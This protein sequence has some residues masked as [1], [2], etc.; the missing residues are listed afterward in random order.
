MGSHCPFG[1][2]KHKLWSK[3]TLRV[4]LTIWL[5]TTKSQ[6]STRF[7]C[8]QTTCNIPLE[9]ALHVGYNVF[10]NLIEIRGLH[11]KLWAPKVIGI[12]VMGILGLPLGSPGTKNHLDVALVESCIVYYKGDGGG[13]PQVWAVV[14]LVSP[15]CPW[16]FLTP[17]VPQLCTNHLVLVLCRFM[18]VVEACEFLL[19]PSLSSSTP[20]YLQT[21]AN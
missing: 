2:L 7:P 1:H 20:L 10:L 19:V 3:E 14:S 17:K 21:I 18:W 4:K 13:Y 11:A 9:K 15:S 16:L 8:M 12:L 5:S 6:E